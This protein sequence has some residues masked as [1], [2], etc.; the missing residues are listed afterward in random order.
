[1]KDFT[2]AIAEI[3]DFRGVWHSWCGMA[4]EFRAVGMSKLGEVRSFVEQALRTIDNLDDNAPPESEDGLG[5]IRDLLY[6]A[7]QRIG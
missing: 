6:A 2:V 1:M 7:V 5:H 4:Q 3:L